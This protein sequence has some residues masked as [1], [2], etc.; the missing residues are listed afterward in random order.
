MFLISIVFKRWKKKCRVP[1]VKIVFNLLEGWCGWRK[2][3]PGL[4]TLESH[5]RRGNSNVSRTSSWAGKEIFE[6]QELAQKWQPSNLFRFR[7]HMCLRAICRRTNKTVTFPMRLT[8]KCVNTHFVDNSIWKGI[9]VRCPVTQTFGPNNLFVAANFFFSGLIA[10]MW[11]S[12]FI[13]IRLIYIHF[14]S[15]AWSRLFHVS[16]FIWTGLYRV[17]F[18]HRRDIP[19]NIDRVFCFACVNGAA[20]PS[21]PEYMEEEVACINNKNLFIVQFVYRKRS[22]KLTNSV[23]TE[24]N[25]MVR[26]DPFLWRICSVWVW[27]AKKWKKMQQRQHHHRLPKQLRND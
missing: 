2:K 19:F 12:V 21:E 25:N 27:A 3:M 16:K 4:A 23:E 20:G 9:D 6:Y 15:V 11:Q 26:F 14:E 17:H 8:T 13:S 7:M 22:I 10:R 5:F 24:K 1:S 18:D